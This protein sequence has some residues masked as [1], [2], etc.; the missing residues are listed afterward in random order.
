MRVHRTIRT[1]IEAPSRVATV[2]Q[3]PPLALQQATNGDTSITIEIRSNQ[4]ITRVYLI[5]G[6]PFLLPTRHS[7]TETEFCP[8]YIQPYYFLYK[9]LPLLSRWV[10]RAFSH[11]NFA[12]VVNFR[13][14]PSFASVMQDQPASSNCYIDDQYQC[15]ASMRLGAPRCG[16]N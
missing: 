4:C 1:L 8:R 5:P 9:L 6:A 14:M 2:L 13:A 10:D 11:V 7:A 16:S 3:R 12:D 15:L